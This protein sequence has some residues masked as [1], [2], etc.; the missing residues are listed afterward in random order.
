MYFRIEFGKPK[1]VRRTTIEDP[2]VP[3]NAKN[4]VEVFGGAESRSGIQVD[5]NVALTFSAVYACVRILSETLAS[6]P[7]NIYKQSGSSKSIDPEHPLQR[8]LHDEPCEMYTSF[9]WR[10]LMM[11]S[12]LLWGNGYSKIIRD[13][14]YRPMWL[15]FIH[16]SIVEPFQV[17]RN[18]KTKTLRYKIKTLG[19][20]EFI[21]AADMVHFKG[22]S[23]DGIKG[24]S[25]IEISQDSIGL[26]LAAERFGSEFFA[27][28]ASFNGLLSTDQAIKKDQLDLVADSWKKRYTGEGNRW[29]TPVLPF[30]FK[31]NM[32]GIPPEQA[33]YIAS[34]KFQIEEVSRIYG[35]PLHLIN[36]LDRASFN[37][38]EHQG[39]AFVTYTMRQWCVRLE[40]ELNRK[41][42]REDEK[43]TYYTRFNLEGLLRGD[44][45]ARAAFYNTTVTLG[46][47]TRNEVRELEDRNPLEGLDE[48]LTPLNLKDPVTPD[49]IPE[50]NNLQNDDNGDKT[51]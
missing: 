17:I 30:G 43:G 15:D 41:L 49:P 38:I 13:K 19:K 42:L 47:L 7:L 31:Y 6:L 48:P 18:D 28:G 9:D 27:N 32:V 8:L 25:P 36:D 23:F 12:V 3:I 11:A 16:P 2:G 22:I 37:N 51:V 5:E 20:E 46:V 26:G 29:K 33:Q 39:I 35:V 34:R 45:A 50:P 1:E 14:K 44:S 24:K 40:Q 10:Q 21:E 4:I